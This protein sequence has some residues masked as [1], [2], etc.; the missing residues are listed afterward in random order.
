MRRGSA[1]K[2]FSSTTVPVSLGLNLL[3]IARGM[4]NYAPATLVSM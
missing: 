1:K 2:V 3:K 4:R